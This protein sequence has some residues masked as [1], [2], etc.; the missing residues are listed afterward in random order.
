MRASFHTK[1]LMSALYFALPPVTLMLAPA[2]WLGTGMRTTTAVAFSADVKPEARS[3]TVTSIRERPISLISGRTLNGRVTLS[4]TRYFIS[5]NAP[6]GG[7]NVMVFSPENLVR[8]T[9]WWNVMSSSSMLLLRAHEKD[10]HARA[11]MKAQIEG[12][13]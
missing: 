13:D 11:I 8:S 6:S 3:L 4:V 9:H 12:I 5:S 1:Q 2:V 7:T 10:H